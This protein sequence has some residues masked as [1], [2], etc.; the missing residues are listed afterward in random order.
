[1]T[2]NVKNTQVLV[3]TD[4]KLVIKYNEIGGATPEASHTTV[5]V[6]ISASA[7]NSSDGK[8]MTGVAV[9]RVWADSSPGAL[10]AAIRW[11]ADTDMLIASTGESSGNMKFFQDYTLGGWGGLTKTGTNP[12]GD[13]TIRTNGVGTGEQFYFI[14][15]MRKLF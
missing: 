15:E 5:L 10:E 3:N 8:T 11:S 2:D 14:I 4:R 6:D 12:T 1:M 9:E 13:I 7:Y